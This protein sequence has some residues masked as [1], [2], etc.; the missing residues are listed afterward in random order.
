M[1]ILLLCHQLEFSNNFK[2]CPSGRLLFIKIALQN[3]GRSKKA[4]HYYFGIVKSVQVSQIKYIY[5]FF[6]SIKNNQISSN[7]MSANIQQI[8]SL[9]IHLNSMKKLPNREVQSYTS[10]TTQTQNNGHCKQSLPLQR[11]PHLFLHQ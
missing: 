10:V 2:Q 4:S 9:V 11:T 3:N 1:Y 5:S 7:V 8:L 6:G